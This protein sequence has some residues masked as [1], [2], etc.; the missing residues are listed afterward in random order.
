MVAVACVISA[1]WKFFGYF[2]CYLEQGDPQN[3]ACRPHGPGA[4]FGN[5]VF[6]EYSHAHLFT[7]YL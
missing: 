5:Q 6:L 2:L 4:Y 1:L 3:T 7:Y